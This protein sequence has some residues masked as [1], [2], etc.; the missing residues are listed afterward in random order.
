MD[1][2]TVQQKTIISTLH[3]FYCDDCGTYIGQTK[4]N[5]NGYYERLGDID[6]EIYVFN[7][8]F[9]LIKCLCDSC[10]YNFIQNL[11]NELKKIGF[12]PESEEEY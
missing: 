3:D 8:R 12:V 6:F 7:D 10:K 9:R 2:T 4:E 11:K 1:K 5:D